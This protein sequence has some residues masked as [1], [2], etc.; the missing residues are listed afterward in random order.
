MKHTLHQDI[1]FEKLAK[2]CQITLSGAADWE[3]GR[4]KR[5]NSHEKVDRNKKKLKVVEEGIEQEEETDYLS[6]TT[7]MSISDT[8]W[9]ENA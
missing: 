4:D 2:E 3:G 5:K 6:T 7:N 8:E 1:G 9:I